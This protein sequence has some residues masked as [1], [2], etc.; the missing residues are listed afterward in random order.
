MEGYVLSPTDTRDEADRPHGKIVNLITFQ[1]LN[2]I[3]AD[4]GSLVEL[5]FA[6]ICHEFKK[7]AN[8]MLISL[9]EI[10]KVNHEMKK[11]SDRMVKRK[12][13]RGGR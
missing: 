1:T 4:A 6:A 2:T 13:M 7:N 12:K 10:N 5:V 3:P 8:E 9:N 11:T